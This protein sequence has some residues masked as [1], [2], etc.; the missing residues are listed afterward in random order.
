MKF[1]QTKNIN[2]R[3]VHADDWEDLFR[4]LGDENSQKYQIK[5]IYNKEQCIQEILE[6]SK[7]NTCWSFCLKET[8]EVV[9]FVTLCQA[10]PKNSSIFKLH[11][12]ATNA[13]YENGYVVEVA[14]RM[15]QYAFEEL[16]AHRVIGSTCAL[17]I[18]SN[19]VYLSIKMRKEGVLQR[20]HTYRVTKT[21]RPIWWDIYIFAIL[22]E[23]WLKLIK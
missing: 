12:N 22:K 19:R 4:L 10:E 14:N 15:L 20:A 11:F 3:R 7:Y 23:E 21:K 9:G 6:M 17:D 16:S 5:G 8:G 2:I 1:M 13:C 18:L